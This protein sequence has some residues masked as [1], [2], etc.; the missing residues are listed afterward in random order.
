[1]KSHTSH[2]HQ[3]QQQSAAS[4]KAAAHQKRISVCMFVEDAKAVGGGQCRVKRQHHH[5]G[6]KEGVLF[7]C[8][9]GR[10]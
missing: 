7:V 5:W 9:V 4:A 2:A 3:M 8:L 1:M 6:K 10:K